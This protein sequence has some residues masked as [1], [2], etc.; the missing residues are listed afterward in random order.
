MTIEKNKRMTIVYQVLK[1]IEIVLVLDWQEL[2]KCLVLA[3]Q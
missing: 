2:E 3:I 1:T